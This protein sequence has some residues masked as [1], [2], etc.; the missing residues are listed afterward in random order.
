MGEVEFLDISRCR[1]PEGDF[2]LVTEDFL[3][4]TAEGREF[5]KGQSP[6]RNATLTS[7]ASGEA[8]IL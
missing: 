5:I 2:G 4:P 8:I 7:I 1:N 6:H 3:E